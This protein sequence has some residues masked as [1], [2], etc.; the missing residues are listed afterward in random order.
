MRKLHHRAMPEPDDPYIG[1]SLSNRPQMLA[2][3]AE[4]AHLPPSLIVGL[5]EV[6][7]ASAPEQRG[8]SSSGATR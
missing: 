7:D 3:E 5:W 2:L 8:R 4:L 6:I 1:W